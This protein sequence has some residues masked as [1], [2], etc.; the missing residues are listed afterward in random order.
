MSWQLVHASSSCPIVMGP[1]FRRKKCVGERMAQA[2]ATDEIKKAETMIPSLVT[3]YFG[4]IPDEPSAEGMPR[5]SPKNDQ[6]VASLYFKFTTKY[7]ETFVK[8]L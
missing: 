7:C 4:F 1:L 6:S 2:T 8:L 5:T 3:Q